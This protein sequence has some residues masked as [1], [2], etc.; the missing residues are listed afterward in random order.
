VLVRRTQDPEYWRGF[1]P[2]DEDIEYVRDLIVESGRPMAARELSRSV[3]YR[4]V[5]RERARIRELMDRGR[6][7]RPSDAY[8]Q[9]QELIFPALDFATG[10]VEGKRPGHWPGHGDFSV[11]TVRFDDGTRDFAAGFA[12]PHKLNESFDKADDQG[13]SLSP[14]S[15]FDRFGGVVPEALERA[16]LTSAAQGF[17]QYDH[18]WF[19]RDLMPDVHVGYLNLAEAVVEVAWESS[20]QAEE[21]QRPLN[22]DDILTQV[23]LQGS[24]ARDVARFALDLALSADPRFVD[25]GSQDEH[26]W[27][28]RRLIPPHML[29]VPVRLRYEPVQFSVEAI[30]TEALNLVWGVADELSTMAAAAEGRAG[31]QQQVEFVLSYPHRRAGTLPLT[32]AIAG[33]LPQRSEGL[34]VITLLDE[35]NGERLTVWIS[36]GE[37]YVASL[38]DWYDRH[39]IPAGAYI[40]LA[41]T[42][43]PDTFA[44]SYRSKKRT[45]R[46]Y[47]R[48]NIPQN[49]RLS[50][51][52]RRQPMS[53]E[54]DETM[55]MVDDNTEATDQLWREMAANPRPISELLLETFAELAKLSPQGT[56]HFN[57]LYTAI[58]VV[59]RCPPEPILAELSLDWRYVGVGS[60]YYAMD[61]RV[62]V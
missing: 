46:E 37:H 21:S 13:E 7:Y 45:Q 33:L 28:L 12:E 51:E 38:G 11:I 44:I 16:L 36:H 50:F 31:G 58:N 42:G 2:T 40:A 20:I 34:G 57:T 61:E 54:F 62:A 14:E 56:V 5:H 59:R 48:A 60:G 41:R 32:P 8:E 39:Q 4:R 55:V 9:G 53:V 17:V 47:V 10:V 49:G 30:P 43:K 18:R 15:I 6:F 26:L 52:I 3:V 1:S 35:A 23:D 22:T 27:L 25:V 24:F 29:E 19:L